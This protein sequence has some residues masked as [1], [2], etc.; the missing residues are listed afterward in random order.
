MI[1]TVSGLDGGT[2]DQLFH[3]IVDPAQLPAERNNAEV[4]YR[5]HEHFLLH[6]A[7]R[8]DHH[9]VALLLE[10]RCCDQ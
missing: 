9:S 6:R 3:I 7:R 4:K 2:L 5:D 8:N 1:T 10:V